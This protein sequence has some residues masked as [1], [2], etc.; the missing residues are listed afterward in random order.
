[1]KKNSTILIVLFFLAGAISCKHPESGVAIASPRP[2]FAREY[3]SRSEDVILL[4][5]CVAYAE[6]TRNHL[7][8]DSVSG[9]YKIGNICRDCTTDPARDNID[10]CLDAFVSG[11]RD[12]DF[13]SQTA[14]V[15][16]FKIKQGYDLMAD[17]VFAGI[18]D[19]KDEEAKALEGRIDAVPEISKIYRSYVGRDRKLSSLSSSEGSALL[20][21]LAYYLSLQNDSTMKRI[22]RALL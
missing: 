19:N 17:V 13:R 4:L 3:D 20:I 16:L 22:V 9:F 2:S 5:S 1:M 21:H 8:P 11:N 18:G 10:S 15:R 12:I 7:N 14:T 6:E